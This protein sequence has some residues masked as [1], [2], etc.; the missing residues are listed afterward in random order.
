MRKI[1]LECT[2]PENK[3][4]GNSYAK[5]QFKM[6]RIFHNFK[7]KFPIKY[8]M[9]EGKDILLIEVVLSDDAVGKLHHRLNHVRVSGEPMKYKII[10]IVDEVEHKEDNENRTAT[11]VI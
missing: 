11:N 6:Y 3:K 5:F 9:K 7:K 1:K 4:I 8:F 2:F 10:E